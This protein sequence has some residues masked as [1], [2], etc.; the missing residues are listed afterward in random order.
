MLPSLTR[1]PTRRTGESSCISC[2]QSALDTSARATRQ[3]LG[4]IIEFHYLHKSEFLILPSL[5]QCECL[6]SQVAASAAAAAS[7]AIP[8]LSISKISS[9]N[10][11]TTN[12][13]LPIP[14]HPAPPPSA[15]RKDTRG[16]QK[17]IVYDLIICFVWL[18]DE[19]GLNLHNS[20]VWDFYVIIKEP[21]PN[22]SLPPPSSSLAH[23]SALAD[24]RK[25]RK[26][27]GLNPSL[28]ETSLGLLG[29]WGSECGGGEGSEIF[30]MQGVV[31]PTNHP[32]RDLRCSFGRQRKNRKTES[33]ACI[34]N[35]WNEIEYLNVSF[36]LGWVH[37][38][39]CPFF[40]A[41]DCK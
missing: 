35:W 10:K 9:W 41:T 5:A 17:M 24:G 22:L 40:L 14:F 19:I 15:S 16:N 28:Y 26:M 3:Q 12:S 34:H 6:S 38:C 39:E 2:Q 20:F 25:M 27:K 32:S 7:D 8:A 13:P 33:H 11:Q 23:Y 4:E 29:C 1:M 36:A 18:W 21:T 31:H 30:S 37:L